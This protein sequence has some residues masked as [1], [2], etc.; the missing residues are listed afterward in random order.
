MGDT[1]RCPRCGLD[2]PITS[3]NFRSKSKGTR[4]SYCRSCSNAS[5]RDWYSKP[6]NKDH[7]LQ[8]L[9]ARRKR[10]I[11]RNKALVEKLK[12]VPCADCGLRYPIAAM[13][14]DHLEDTEELISKLVYTVGVKRL[15]MEIAECEVVC[16]N[17]HRIRTAR[18]S[19]RRAVAEARGL[20][21]SYHGLWRS[22]VSA[23]RLGRRGRRFESDQ[24]DSSVSRRRHASH[25]GLELPNRYN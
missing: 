24:P 17:C 7:H 13:D 14:F 10:R 18:R 12:S 22:L 8:V 5:W 21:S 1:K 23:R 6:G 25:L 19:A 2:L 16:A 11:A 3:F 20:P 9:R 15:L 4:Q